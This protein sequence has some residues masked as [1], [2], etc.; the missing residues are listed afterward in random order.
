MPVPTWFHVGLV[1]YPPSPIR[2][3]HGVAKPFD[4]EQ[5]RYFQDVL[6][7]YG[8][9]LYLAAKK[10]ARGYLKSSAAGARAG[11]TRLERNAW[12][13]AERQMAYEVGS[14]AA[15]RAARSPRAGK[16]T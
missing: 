6:E 3:E 9:P 1:A 12:R 16:Q 10:A 11:R 2:D 5:H 7:T 13:I 8:D 14:S 15:R 4:V